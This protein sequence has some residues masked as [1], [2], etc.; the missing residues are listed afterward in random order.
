MGIF[1]YFQRALW[2]QLFYS[3]SI[4]ILVYGLAA[5][6]SVETVSL[7]TDNIGPDIE[8]IGDD[9]NQNFDEQLNIP[10]VDLGSL[11]FFSGNLVIDLLLNF[12]TA[13]PNMVNI[14]ISA[15]FLFVPVEAQLQTEI[16]EFILVALT[17]MY[18]LGL[19]GFLARSRSS[20]ALP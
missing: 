8:Q 6:G 4:T 1:D 9:I 14:L 12:I 19:V 10:V 16:K 13:I 11:V 15:Y 17:V 5:M 18:T 20:G 7:F 2:V 3:F